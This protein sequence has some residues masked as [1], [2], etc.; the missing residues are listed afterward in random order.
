MKRNILLI[1]FSAFFILNLSAQSDDE[2][3]GGDDDSVFS[4]DGIIELE[5]IQTDYDKK[6]EN[7]NHGLLF[8]TGSVK[9]GGS[10]DLSLTTMTSFP[11]D[12]E[13]KD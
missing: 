11:K 5:D 10:F 7:L 3:F 13:F 6:T 8:E 9:I 12:K 4:D 2:L 1:I